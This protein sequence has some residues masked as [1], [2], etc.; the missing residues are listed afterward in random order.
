MLPWLIVRVVA[1][2]FVCVFG[3]SGVGVWLVCVVVCLFVGLVG[4]LFVCSFV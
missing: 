2:S 1:R 4:L 3:Y